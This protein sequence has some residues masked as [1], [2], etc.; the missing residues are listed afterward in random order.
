VIKSAF[1]L[2]EEAKATIEG[3]TPDQLAAGMA[4]GGV[5]V[6]D[7]RD[8][9]ERELGY[10]PGSIHIP[11][12]ALEFAAD[13]TSPAADPRLQDGRRV[14]LHCGLG[15]GSALAT[16]RLRE[17]GY[18]ALANLE[19]GYEAWVKAGHRVEYPQSTRNRLL[20]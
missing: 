3:V 11:R 18:E 5:V 14:V 15:F 17:M 6:V 4:S 1:K 9:Q 19:G 2:V 10:I 7:V 8:S 12:V 20:G 16:A 13:P